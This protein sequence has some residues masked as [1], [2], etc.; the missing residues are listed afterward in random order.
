MTYKHREEAMGQGRGCGC[1]I[2]PWSGNSRET[3]TISI[4]VLFEWTSFLEVY[5]LI[6]CGAY[7]GW[8]GG[9]D[10]GPSARAGNSDKSCCNSSCQLSGITGLE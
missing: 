5:V 7:A 4:S 1:L 6:L 9:T 3:E 10:T 2:R 8:G